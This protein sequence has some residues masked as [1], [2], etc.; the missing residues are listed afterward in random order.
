MGLPLLGF[1][2]GRI[3]DNDGSERLGASRVII[4]ITIFFVIVAIITTMMITI[5]MT[6]MMTTQPPAW[7]KRRARQGDALRGERTLQGAFGSK[8]M[9]VVMVTVMIVVMMSVVDCS[10]C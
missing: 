10:L 8:V 1:C 2:G 6:T 7:S 4:I 9:I 5:V 3:D